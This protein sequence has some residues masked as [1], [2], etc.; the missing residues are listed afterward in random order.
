VNPTLVARPSVRRPRTKLGRGLARMRVR[1]WAWVQVKLVVGVGWPVN[2]LLHPPR[3]SAAALGPALAVVA[4]VTILGATVS[5][6][7]L[8][9]A[10]QRGKLAVIGLTVETVGIS[11]VLAGTVAY[12]LTQVALLSGPDGEQRIAFSWY[13]YGMA[14]A[15]A[16]RLAIVLTERHEQAVRPERTIS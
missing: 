2:L 1:D 3:A 12:W 9:A 13:A 15:F 10:R 7:G 4:I 5:L 11:F 6:V 14:A 16:A 8:I